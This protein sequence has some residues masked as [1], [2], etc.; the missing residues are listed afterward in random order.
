ML[1]EQQQ[2]IV[3]EL[4]LAGRTFQCIAGWFDCSISTIRRIRKWYRET[5]RW[6]SLPG[7]VRPKKTTAR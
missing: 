4:T 3:V 2:N 6:Q 5:G 1:S 7:S